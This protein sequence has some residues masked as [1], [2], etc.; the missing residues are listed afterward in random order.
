MINQTEVAAQSLADL[1]R[2]HQAQTGDSYGDIARRTGLS[3][4]K[5]GQLVQPGA[6]Y[7]VRHETV[8]KLATGLRLPLITVERAAI[9]SSGF[10]DAVQPD[11]VRD[12]ADRLE[13]LPD[14]MLD[15]VEDFIETLER[16][17]GT[18]VRPMPS[19]PRGGSARADRS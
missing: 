18:A 4:A 12:I 2:E 9:V 11:R 13:L 7:L 3:K 16:R 19:R 1:I 15:L 17:I 6:E 10:G 14:D 8:T 5:V